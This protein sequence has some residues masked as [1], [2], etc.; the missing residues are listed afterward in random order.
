[1]L[2]WKRPNRKLKNEEC[3][4]PLERLQAEGLVAIPML[5]STGAP[6]PR[7]ITLSFQPESKSPVTGSA[8]EFEPLYLRLVQA[9]NRE[10]NSTFKLL[11]ERWYYLGYRIAFGAHLCYLVQ[12]EKLPGRY[13]AC[14]QFSSPAW[15]MTPRDA[16]IGWSAE[17]RKRNLQLIVS[18][19]RFL[20]SSFLFV[21]L[22]ACWR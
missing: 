12:S 22:L 13:L 19:S 8:G 15:K 20:I 9:A 6:G 21:T 17:Q 14:L 3:R 16:W 18:N 11:I 1:L 10:L 4:T 7:R 2:D 5:R